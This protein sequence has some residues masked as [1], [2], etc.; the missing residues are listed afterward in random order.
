M[1]DWAVRVYVAKTAHYKQ[2]NAVFP[3]LAK[4]L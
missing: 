2:M 4:K 1:P 3:H